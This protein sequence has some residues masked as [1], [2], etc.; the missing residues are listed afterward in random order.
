MLDLESQA[1]EA[2]WF[3]GVQQFL[4]PDF[5]VLTFGASF[6]ESGGNGFV[7]TS[8]EVDAATED[9]GN[10]SYVHTH[11]AS[12]RN[13]RI[14]GLY[15]S[16]VVG[17]NE[18][19]TAEIGFLEGAVGTDGATFRFGFIPQGS[20]IERDDFFSSARS[21]RASL[22]SYYTELV[23]ITKR[24]DRTL[25]PIDIDLSFLAGQRVQFVLMVDSGRTSGQDWAVWVNPQISSRRRITVRNVF[26]VAESTSGWSARRR[27]IRR[28]LFSDQVA[29]MVLMRGID[30]RAHFTDFAVTELRTRTGVDSSEY[31]NL[32]PIEA[33]L[34]TDASSQVL[35]W[36][37]ALEIDGAGRTA[38]LAQTALRDWAGNIFHN[39]VLNAD[40]VPGAHLSFSDSGTGSHDVLFEDYW[41]VDLD[42]WQAGGFSPGPFTV[43]GQSPAGPDHNVESYLGSRSIDREV[44]V[45]RMAGLSVET[46]RYRNAGE[47]SDYSFDVVYR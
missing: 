1:T 4:N 32:D 44:S 7:Q 38:S 6:G 16:Y 20:A 24:Y 35:I 15:D 10:A 8:D 5:D 21:S 42:R 27:R 26:C 3:G 40:S 43:V 39:P 30:E 37:K 25:R 19:F 18:T 28:N 31:L 13:G 45:N 23:R 33:T 47:Y 12:G 34:A 36:V 41:A 9:G 46:R 22:D 14:V 2:A 29:M 11:P 17:S